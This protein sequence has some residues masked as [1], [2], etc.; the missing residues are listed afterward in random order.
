MLIKKMNV[1][2]NITHQ[3][4]QHS[5]NIVRVTVP[6]ICYGSSSKNVETKGEVT[7]NV[8]F[9]SKVKLIASRLGF[10]IEEKDENIL[11]LHKA[12]FQNEN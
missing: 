2:I 10:R 11:T 1:Q 4:Y 6:Y 12:F 5:Q 7:E 8:K 3:R 9:N